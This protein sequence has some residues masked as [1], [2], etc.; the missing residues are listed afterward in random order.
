[1][2][3]AESKSPMNLVLFIF[4]IEHTSR[5]ARVLAMPGGNILLVGVGG[6]G[7]Q[8]LTKLATFMCMYTIK[9]IELSK[10]Y[11]IQDWRDD[12]KNIL[13]EAAIGPKEVVFLF[14]D[15]QVKY[16]QFVEDINSM[17]NTGKIPNILPWMRRPRSSMGCDQC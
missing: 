4:A 3:N 1:M 8:S 12:A 2:Y 13:M 5:I 7:R 6:S 16:E 17:L 9:Q 14:S 11:A 10:T 15:T